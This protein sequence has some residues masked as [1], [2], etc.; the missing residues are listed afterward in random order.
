MG[1]TKEELNSAGVYK[2]VN[3]E[4]GK[5]YYGSTTK[6]FKVRWKE[7]KNNLRDAKHHCIHLQNAYNTYGKEHFKYVIIDIIERPHDSTYEEFRMI[8]F[9]IEQEYLDMYWDH[10]NTCYNIAKY[11]SGGGGNKGRTFSEEARKNMSEAHKGQVSYRKGIFGVFSHTD[12]T[13]EKIRL[14]QIGKHPSEDAYG[15]KLNWEKV[16][17]IRRMYK[18]EEYTQQQ[19][20]N[21]YNVCLAA[22]C[23][24]ICYNTWVRENE[25]QII[26]KRKKVKHTDEFKQSISERM[27]NRIGNKHPN[28][29]KKLSEEEKQKI[30]DF[31]K[32]KWIGKKSNSAKLTWILVDEIREK[33]KTGNYSTRSLGKEYNVE[34]S[35]IG[36][37]IRYKTWKIKPSSI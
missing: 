15:A 37:I 23:N 28:F 20:A 30:S 17:E 29:G 19:L 8:M 2:I 1:Y 22:I 12:E 4:N 32:G 7:H 5:A 36:A 10:G 24:V 13:K 34:H 21:L 35:T 6:S 16:D 31:H 9:S 27:K 26:F 33:Y 3:V 11:A 14:L 25:E 18:T